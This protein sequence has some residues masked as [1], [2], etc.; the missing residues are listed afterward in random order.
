MVGP[1]TYSALRDNHSARKR[2]PNDRNISNRDA[3]YAHRWDNQELSRLEERS[4]RCY[5]FLVHAK[6][7]LRLRP[8]R[9]AKFTSP[10]LDKA[11]RLL[12]LAGAPIRSRALVKVILK[13]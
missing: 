4:V 13:S 2:K 7:V 3:F 12:F 1:L 9:A 8:G 5:L 10:D 6:V 11:A